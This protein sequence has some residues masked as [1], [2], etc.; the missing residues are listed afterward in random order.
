[1]DYLIFVRRSDKLLTEGVAI[2]SRFIIWYKNRS[3]PLF[4]TFAY[5]L[6]LSILN[7]QLDNLICVIFEAKKLYWKIAL[8]KSIRKALVNLLKCNVISNTLNNFNAKKLIPLEAIK[9]S[10]KTISKTITENLSNNTMG[11]TV[12]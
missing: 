1:M 3:T 11:Q 5:H 7:P 8:F 12:C 10:R 4:H 9:A 2:S 6:L